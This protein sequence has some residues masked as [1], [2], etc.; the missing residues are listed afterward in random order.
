MNDWKDKVA[1]ITGGGSG[2]GYALG[3]ALA[4]KGVRVVLADIEQTSL[5]KALH[6]MQKEGLEAE[7]IVT[8]VMEQDSVD[9][10]AK[11]GR[12]HV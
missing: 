8:N 6:E 2:I 11:I 1:V 7:G 4:R 12:A 9:A 3:T 5:D 10:L